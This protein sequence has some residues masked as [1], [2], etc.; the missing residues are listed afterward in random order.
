MR[1]GVEIH[2]TVSTRTFASTIHFQLRKKPAALPKEGGRSGP[3]APPKGIKAQKDSLALGP[4]RAAETEKEAKRRAKKWKGQEPPRETFNR[5][6][7]LAMEAEETLS[8]IWGDFSTPSSPRALPP[9]WTALPPPPNP[10]L[11]PR[12]RNPKVLGLPTPSPRG[13]CDGGDE[14]Y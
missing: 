2:K 6:G 9:I 4:Q 3:S 14:A 5:F 7:P 10:T 12:W 11:C 1:G 8:S 13:P